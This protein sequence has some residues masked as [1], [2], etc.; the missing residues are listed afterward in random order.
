MLGIIYS[1]INSDI[2]ILIH[3]L[4]SIFIDEIS[5]YLS[6]IIYSSIKEYSISFFIYD[7]SW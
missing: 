7:V 2:L 6:N 5:Y 4:R 1:Y 3:K